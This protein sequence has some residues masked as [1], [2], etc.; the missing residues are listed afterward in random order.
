VRAT[1]EGDDLDLGAVVEA[2]RCDRVVDSLADRLVLV[3]VD[4]QDLLALCGHRYTIG[5]HPLP[6]RGFE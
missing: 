2:Q 5:R 3:G 4:E 1:D 6:A